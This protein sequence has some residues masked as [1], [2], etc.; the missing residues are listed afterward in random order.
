MKSTVF[1]LSTIFLCVMYGCS[2][3]SSFAVK[4]AANG[5]IGAAVPSTASPPAADTGDTATAAVNRTPSPA[6]E[7]WK[8]M[9]S[10]ED[11][12]FESHAVSYGGKLYVIS[13]MC[14]GSIK[15]EGAPPPDANKYN[16]INMYDPVMGKWTI[17]DAK[18]SKMDGCFS[19]VAVSGKLYILGSTDSSSFEVYDTETG[20][21]AVKCPIGEPRGE[22]DIGEANGK[23]YAIGGYITQSG[24][25]T[26]TN[27]VEEYDEANDVW[28]RKADMPTARAACCVATLDGKIYVIGGVRS[29]AVEVY[30]PAADAWEPKK[31]V[32]ET[33]CDG[34]VMEGKIY[35]RSAFGKDIYIYDNVG[36]KWTTIAEFPENL[37]R[38]HGTFIEGINNK[39]YIFQDYFGDSIGLYEYSME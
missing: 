7:A 28:I 13:A 27:V 38:T 21:S 39:I 8:R 32:P 36:D 10:P 15:P 22:V 14:A 11:S 37:G 1:I 30:D 12:I 20:T 31:N 19:A 9:A 33:I 35:A 16:K 34:F 2:T 5:G 17:L 24:V 4:E 29:N 25:L 6:V 3:P 18:L 23:I 26:A